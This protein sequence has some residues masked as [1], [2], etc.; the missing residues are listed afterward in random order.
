MHHL[1]H[2]Q[3]TEGKGRNRV[4]PAEVGAGRSGA[5]HPQNSAALPQ[6]FHRRYNTY[7]PPSLASLHS[8]LRNSLLQDP[9]QSSLRSIHER[10]KT[11]CYS[12]LIA[13][14]CFEASQEHI[15]IQAS[16]PTAV[17]SLIKGISQTQTTPSIPR[18][19]STIWRT[20]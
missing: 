5:S 14:L 6:L 10:L 19:I 11:S 1:C 20:N 13:F 9:P 12:V 18:P 7:P 2:V 16:S 17:P 8:P 3:R 4:L 15:S